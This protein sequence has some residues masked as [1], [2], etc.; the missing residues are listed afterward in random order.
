MKKILF[1]AFALL[2]G[3]VFVLLSLELFLRI[4]PKF[5]YNYIFSKFK[6][7]MFPKAP[8]L[9]PSTLLGYE[10]IPNSGPWDWGN[11]IT[12]VNS[13]GL[14]SKEYKLH[15]DK[16]V[17]RILILGDSIAELSWG[18]EL[19]EDHL[20]N[21]VRSHAR[22]KNFEIWN[23]GVTG[24][25]VRRYALY[26]KYRGLKYEPDM[27]IIFFCLNDF[28]LNTSVFYKTRDGDLNYYFS[29]SEISKKYNVNSFLMK[30]SYLYRII[31]LKLNSYLLDM[32]KRKNIDPEAEVG[33]YY[34]QMIKEICESKR[35][36]LFAVVFP[37]L[38]PMN[39]YNGYEIEQYKTIC[40][41]TKD[42]KINYLDLYEYLPEAELY[43]L[44]MTE[45][46]NIHPNREGFRL[47]A[48][49]IYEYLLDSFFKDK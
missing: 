38:M 16:G 3:I 18:S 10:Q 9:R 1:R 44:R 17:F 19:L 12:M 26:L 36:P 42:L 14:F 31:I 30:H 48:K 34:L 4:N 2:T 7:G 43:S 45:E 49:V 22:Y 13:Y 41:V 24:Y 33:R 21:D 39:E 23:A 6:L 37:L 40:K 15:K 27:V 28:S 35:I 25:D 11:K 5:G 29:I 20:N 47:I 46:D 8:H 32:K